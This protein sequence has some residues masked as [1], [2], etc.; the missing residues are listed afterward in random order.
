[1]PESYQ[2]KSKFKDIYWRDYLPKIKD[3]AYAINPD[4]CESI[5]TY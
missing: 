5:E 1:M 2:K 4:E 3:R